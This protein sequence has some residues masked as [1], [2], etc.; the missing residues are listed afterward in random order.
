MPSVSLRGSANSPEGTSTRD[1]NYLSWTISL[2]EAAT[3]PVTVNLRYL[4]GSALEAVDG[5]RWGSSSPTSVTFA[6]GE[7]S[8]QVRYRID[9]DA[10]PEADE[11]IVLE[12]YEVSGAAVLAGD[13]RVLRSESWIL[14]DD[15]GSTKLALY[16]ANPIVNEAAG[17]VVFDISLS[18]PAPTDFSVSYRTIDGTAR[19]GSDY[20]A[21]TGTVSFVEGQSVAQVADPAFLRPGTSKTPRPSRWRSDRPPG[22]ARRRRSKRASSTVRS[23]G[24]RW[25]RGTARHARERRDLR[26]RRRRFHLRRRRRGLHQRGRRHATTRGAGRAAT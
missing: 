5:Y 2:S 24:P 26:V 20:K 8:K 14:D 13:A 1:P 21:T 12:A 11:T 25:G 9:A 3:G 17:E 23:E 10:V 22:S 19:G 7:T 15:G 16:A 4:S 6:V 18:R